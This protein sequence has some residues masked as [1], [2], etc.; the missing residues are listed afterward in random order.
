MRRW[1]INAYSII[2][3]ADN[4]GC[5]VI[6]HSGMSRGH[7]CILGTTLSRIFRQLT[8]PLTLVNV[9][10]F[11]HSGSIVIINLIT[12]FSLYL[13]FISTLSYKP[14]PREFFSTTLLSQIRH[15]WR[16]RNCMPYQSAKKIAILAMTFTYNS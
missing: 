8:T 10:A 13:W 4:C 12:S 16:S 2:I 14:V 1:V 5:G 15:S 6:C 3:L 7:C 11:T 9:L